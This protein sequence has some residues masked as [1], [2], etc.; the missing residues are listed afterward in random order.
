[1]GGAVDVTYLILKWL[2]QVLIVASGIYA[3]FSDLYKEQPHGKKRELT[4][5]G[6]I[7][8]AA[9]LTGFM[10]YAVT[11][12]QERKARK[13]DD[14]Y[15]AGLAEGQER[16]NIKQKQLND[17]QQQV[18][19]TQTG[20]LGYL[21]HLILEQEV[22]NGWELSWDAPATV[23]QL[24]RTKAHSLTGK[25]DAYLRTCLAELGVNAR[26]SANGHWMIS[27]ILVRPL[28][29]KNVAFDLSPSE[30]G[31]QVFESILD[32][33]L[34][35]RLAVSQSGGEDL[36][37]LSRLERPESISYTNS[38]V[39]VT[40]RNARVRLGWLERPVEAVLRLDSDVAANAP[41]TV[42]IRSLDSNL[43]LDQTFSTRWTKRQVGSKPHYGVD[44]ADDPVTQ[45]PIYALFS[46]PHQIKG[47]FNKLLFSFENAQ[48]A[49]R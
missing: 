41:A 11:D 35:P 12:F 39:T 4:R 45:D 26:A 27:C 7:N 34:S 17:A 30:P 20:E 49:A 47:S 23:I 14:A 5:A 46:G 33:L 19:N 9:L 32:I 13:E 18:I 31:W 28:G 21:H 43:Q 8:L 29:V 42:R 25:D 48:Q 36:V 40:V 37:V 3:M 44:P 38:R 6:W 10:L 1:M 16:L 2:S 15:K 22:V 24:A